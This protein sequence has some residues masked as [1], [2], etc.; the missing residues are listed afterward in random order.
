MKLLSYFSMKS[1]FS[2]YTIIQGYYLILLNYL[3]T[4]F[5]L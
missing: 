5:A 3:N 1:F 2:S 4:V